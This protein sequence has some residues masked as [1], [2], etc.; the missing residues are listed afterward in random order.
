MGDV[1]PSELAQDIRMSVD[2]RCRVLAGG[3]RIMCAW[4]SEEQ[5]NL[6]IMSKKSSR[7]K[8]GQGVEYH[9]PIAHDF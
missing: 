1:N 5:W 9:L 2:T 3:V 7:G 6:W 4:N 8:E